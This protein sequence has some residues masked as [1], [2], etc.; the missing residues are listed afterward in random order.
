MCLFIVCT[1]ALEC[2]LCESR[3]FFC[4][5]QYP[6][7]WAVSGSEAALNARLLWCEA[8]MKPLTPQPASWP[9][10]K[11]LPHSCQT[12]SLASSS[13]LDRMSYKFYFAQNFVCIFP[14]LPK[15]GFSLCLQITVINQPYAYGWDSL[16]TSWVWHVSGLWLSY[17]P[18]LMNEWLTSW[19]L[20]F[21]YSYYDCI[22]NIIPSWL[23]WRDKKLHNY[24]FMKKRNKTVY[25]PYFKK[26]FIGA[27]PVV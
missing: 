22:L 16:S 9:G 7:T 19:E 17:A 25:V 14:F 21:A 24:H 3:A 13:L 23:T 8:W 15:Q 11:F 10:H 26:M 18:H 27:G 5:H 6:R 1:P 4:Y 20:M 12:C 2:K